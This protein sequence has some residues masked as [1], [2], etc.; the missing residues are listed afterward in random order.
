MRSLSFT[1]LSFFFLTG[2]GE[3]HSTVETAS[4]S[5]AQSIEL[6]FKV[7][8]DTGMQISKEAPWTLQLSNTQG[9]KLELKEGKFESKSFDETLPGFLIKTGTD[10]AVKAGKLD[11]TIRAFVCTLDKKHCYP[12]LHKGSLDWNKG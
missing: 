5:Q 12:Q 7:V 10:G 1:G 2:F 9:L 6:K 3:K 8:P 11:Y 4:T